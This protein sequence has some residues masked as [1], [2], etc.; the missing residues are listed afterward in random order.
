MIKYVLATFATIYL[1]A[2][3]QTDTISTPLSEDGL[4]FTVSVELADF[5]LPDGLH[6][7][8][9]AIYEGEWL[10]ISGRTNGLHDVD[11]TDGDVN[12]SFPVANQ[13]TR[14][15]VVNPN[16]KI[17][18]SRSLYDVNSGLTQ[19]QIDLL[20]V[21]N[22]L[23]YH[24]RNSKTLYL[25]GGYGYDSAAQEMNT[26]TWLTAVDVPKMIKWV[27][28]GSGKTAA[29]CLRQVSHPLL[30]V[31]GGEMWQINA[32]QPCLLA[33]GQNFD[34]NYTAG[35][36]GTYTQQV[37]PFQVIDNGKDIF[38]QPFSQPYPIDTYRRRDLNVVPIIRKNGKSYDQAL[39]TLSGVFT[40]G[41]GNDAGAWTIP[42][43]IYADGSTKTFDPSDPN[44][45]M[46]G[47]NNYAC[48]NMGMY[49]KKEN[50]MYIL[51]F[52]GLSYLIMSDGD[53]A[54]CTASPPPD[55]NILTSCSALPFVNDITTVRID[56][57][58]NYSQ[59]LMSAKFPTIIADFGST[60]GGPIWFGTSAAFMPVESLPMYPNNV[61]AYDKTSSSSFIAGYIVGGIGSSL[62]DTTGLEDSIASPY[63]FQVVVTP[64]P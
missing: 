55:G 57:S 40:L 59:Y 10:L 46:Q 15:Y 17:T 50:N 31:T 25:V 11:N 18:Y 43:E 22:A 14:I 52:G 62:T 19:E 7:F 38:I 24:T 8:A 51:L 1:C 6:S 2:G 39:T 21:T 23:F 33:F 56:A 3:N 35:S 60:S 42:I 53:Q 32:H 36:T 47:M 54:S 34:G 28:N 4:P 27:K 45:F 48:A 61:I 44:T 49:S 12:E 29:S 13:N 16:T 41:T 58:G 9:V 30:Q 20:S 63:I 5:S 37:R 64:N 26:K